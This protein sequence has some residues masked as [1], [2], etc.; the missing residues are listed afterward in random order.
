M[1]EENDQVRMDNEF[2]SIEVVF[3]VAMTLHNYERGNLYM[4]AEFHSYKHG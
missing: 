3:E 2:Y 1:T 4:Q